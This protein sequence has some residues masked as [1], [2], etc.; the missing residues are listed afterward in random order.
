MAA[1][2]Q[3]ALRAVTLPQCHSGH[4]GVPRR[5]VRVAPT[6]SQPI[7][8]RPYKLHPPLG[9]RARAGAETQAVDG[10]Q[11]SA[12]PAPVGPH[13][14]H[15]STEGLSAADWVRTQAGLATCRG[16]QEPA[17][18]TNCLA[19]LPSRP[20]LPRL[21]RPGGPGR[22]MPPCSLPPRTPRNLPVLRPATEESHQLVLGAEPAPGT[23]V[24]GPPAPQPPREPSV[25]FSR[26]FQ[27]RAPSQLGPPRELVPAPCTVFSAGPRPGLDQVRACANSRERSCRGARCQGPPASCRRRGVL[28]GHHTPAP[29]A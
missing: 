26:T 25:T 2:A 9:T 23:Q 8:S 16:P 5:P 22:R 4:Q 13:L 28:C 6:S 18:A 12:H 14:P 27:G 19:V 3:G 24:P 1:A 15:A 17:T 21:G 7:N 10:R 11:L 20:P 29:S